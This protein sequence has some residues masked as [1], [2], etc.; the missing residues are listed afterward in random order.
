MFGIKSSKPVVGLDI[1]SHGIKAVE[2]N[3]RHKAGRDAYSVARI[4]Y[5]PLPHEA[6][7]EGQIID[8]P[9]VAEAIRSVCDKAKI[10]NKD[11]AVSISGNSVI[12]KKISLPAM[13]SDELAESIIWEA[14]HNIPYPYEETN[15]DYVVLKSHGEASAGTEI[16][17]VAVKKEKVAAFAN[18]IG[19]ARKNLVAIEVD[20]FA[21][22]NA[23]EINYPEEVAEQT[24]ALVNM[25]ATVTTIVISDRGTPQLFRDLS[26]GGSLFIESLRKDLNVGLEEAEALLRGR[27]SKTV[28]AFQVDAV[29]SMN[30]RSL[31]DE[32]EKT[33]SFFQA[34]DKREN[35]IERIL[36]GGGL[37]NLRT[38]SAAFEQKFSVKTTLFDPF[39]RVHYNEKKLTSEYYQ[40]MAPFFGVATGLATRQRE[41]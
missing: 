33:F 6:I 1:G 4:G 10:S 28:E 5:Q 30:T 8:A 36:L 7:V 21:L 3:I 2:L 35:R 12:I 11:V 25:G 13:G 41:K 24:V 27:P 18:L 39:R 40:E 22:A 23:L 38:I 26:L 32:V 19:Q 34:E 37:A 31:I 29:L 14:K 20:A 15:V 9:A 17:L 16:L